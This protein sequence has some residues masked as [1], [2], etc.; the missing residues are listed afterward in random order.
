MFGWLAAVGATIGGIA[1]ELSTSACSAVAGEIYGEHKTQNQ[2]KKKVNKF[3]KQLEKRLENL[4]AELKNISDGLHS[5]FYRSQ[6]VSKRIECLRVSEYDVEKN[7]NYINKGNKANNKNNNLAK[8]QIYGNKKYE[9]LDRKIKEEKKKIFKDLYDLL[10]TEWDKKKLDEAKEIIKN[11]K[12]NINKGHQLTLEDV[13]QLYGIFAKKSWFKEKFSPNIIRQNDLLIRMLMDEI[14]APLDKEESAVNEFNMNVS[15]G[16]NNIIN[17]NKPKSLLDA[18]FKQ[19]FNDNTKNEEIKKYRVFFDFLAQY[20][21]DDGINNESDKWEY[22][23]C[24]L[25]EEFIKDKDFDMYED[26]E[27]LPECCE[28][29]LKIANILNDKC[30]SRDC[31]RMKDKIEPILDTKLNSLS[32]QLKKIKIKE[33]KDDNVSK[34][35]NDFIEKQQQPNKYQSLLNKAK[36]IIEVMNNNG[37]NIGLDEANKGKEDEKNTVI[38]NV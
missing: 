6:T 37:A 10:L 38:K 23:E 24:V 13:K 22:D 27:E 1:L 31:N 17:D 14:I 29:I 15:N 19:A 25:V 28:K 9:E 21:G 35:I 11:I 5:G 26:I 2:I 16:N 3:A 18:I 4:N 12:E 36:K 30:E 20:S 8:T 7:N 33:I 32:E 34:A